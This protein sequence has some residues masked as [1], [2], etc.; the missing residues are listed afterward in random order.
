M[1]SAGTLGAL[2]HDRSGPTIEA[3]S[4]AGV[5]ASHSAN[6]SN[7]Q[8]E[9]VEAEAEVVEAE[10]EEAA[11]GEECASPEQASQKQEEATPAWPEGAVVKQEEEEESEE[12]QEAAV[13]AV[14]TP[15][16]VGKVEVE[17]EDYCQ[18]LWRSTAAEVEVEVE[19]EQF[20]HAERDRYA[21]TWSPA[22][23]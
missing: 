1:T 15:P 14:T 22:A 3:G 9:A 16:A 8:V 20:E 12:R 2:A 21:T 23:P 19:E 6:A 13:A 11:E 4:L 17:V 7:V 5:T 10:E 18:H